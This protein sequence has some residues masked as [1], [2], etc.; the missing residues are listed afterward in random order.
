LSTTLCEVTRVSVTGFTRGQR[1]LGWM[2]RGVAVWWDRDRAWTVWGMR[3]LNPFW[4]V[5][6]FQSR[7]AQ[8][9]KSS[10][11]VL[12]TRAGPSASFPFSKT[13]DCF[14]LEITKQSF[15][16]PKIYKFGRATD[17][18]KVNKLTFWP[19]CKISI[20]FEL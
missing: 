14:E 1:K 18:F 19:N 2:R 11:P 8:P 16:S 6:Q 9:V 15:S 7:V 13:F 3:M 20:D 12:L 17:K 4:S 5:G 10:G